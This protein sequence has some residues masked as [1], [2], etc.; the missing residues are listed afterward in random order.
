MKVERT[1]CFVDLA[2]FSALTE[3]HG[4]NAAA[5][6]LEHFTE[7][8]GKSLGSDD[9]LVKTIG[10]AV[11][12]TSRSPKHAVG[13]VAR[14]WDALA[15]EPDFP[16]VRAGIHHGPAVEKRDDVFGAAVNLAARVASQA[17][18]GKVLTTGSTARAAEAL[19][20][21]VTPLGPV[22]LRNI[23]EAVELYALDLNRM[24]TAEVLDPV[25]R[26]RVEP[27]RAAGRLNFAGT[28][29]W[30]CSLRC[31]SLF[32]SDPEAYVAHG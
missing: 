2:G 23:R 26:M 25:C 15:A 13:L 21:G 19:G 29:Y 10:D 27:Q 8:V 9:R 18:G 31:S 4:D 22:R 5:D 28:T 24:P 6:L 14:L 17:G 11:L 1:F 32:A 20:I 7:L 3:A 30:F 16:Q 12:L